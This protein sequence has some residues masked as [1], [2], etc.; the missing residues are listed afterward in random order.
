MLNFYFHKF[1]IIKFFVLCL[2]LI[3]FYYDI[4][5]INGYNLT[6]NQTYETLEIFY[7]YTGGQLWYS[8]FNW[9]NRSISPCLWY[10]LKCNYNKSY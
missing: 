6:L 1:N 4:I 8:N 3:S 7:N 10:G 5:T 2:I 9:L